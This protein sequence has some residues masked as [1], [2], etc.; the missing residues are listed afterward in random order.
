[1]QQPSQNRAGDAKKATGRPR[2]HV[3]QLN[4]EIVGNVPMPYEIP[5]PMPELPRLLQNVAPSL[6]QYL[7]IRPPFK[8][9]DSLVIPGDIAV[10]YPVV[11]DLFKEYSGRNGLRKIVEHDTSEPENTNRT[12]AE[13]V[14]GED[15]K[16]VEKEYY[17]E[18]ITVGNKLALEAE[19]VLSVLCKAEVS[20][21]D[22]DRKSV[23]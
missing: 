17:Y 8:I 21:A 4:E 18:S 14:N 20:S 23:V 12:Q 11:D 16:V 1:M 7:S 6:N 10:K 15:A 5:S 3:Q 22:K 13:E 9:H 2:P 19:A